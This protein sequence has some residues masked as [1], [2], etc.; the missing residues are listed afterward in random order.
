MIRIKKSN[1][2]KRRGQPRRRVKSFWQR[3]VFAVSFMIFI[4]GS[5]SFGVWWV[6]HNDWLFK[7]VKIVKS[8]FILSVAKQGLV[9]RKILVKGRVETSR[10]DILRALR[11][12]RGAPILAFKT[13]LA[14]IRVEGLPWVQQAVIE[15]QLPD[16]IHLHLTE[17]RPL[18]LWQRNGVFSLIDRKGWVIPL[19]DVSA[20]ANLIVIIGDDAPTKAGNFFKI[21][22]R[23]PQL[24][25]QITAAVRVGGRRWNLH[26]NGQTEVLLPEKG[27][28][29]AWTHLAKLYKKHGLL[30]NDL[31]TIDLR[32]ADRVVIRHGDNSIVKNGIQKIPETQLKFKNRTH[33]NLKRYLRPNTGTT[34]ISNKET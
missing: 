16:V 28:D 29:E 33:K 23:E 18:A 2:K 13:E 8:S 15:R 32:L 17:R 27:A 24:E 22:A 19:G 26:L 1:K 20:Y 31:K 25:S 30:F 7:S 10:K 6:W 3:S 12:K 11:L 34:P 21:L 5:I 14:R 9:V 4:F